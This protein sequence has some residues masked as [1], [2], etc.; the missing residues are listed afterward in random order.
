MLSLFVLIL[1]GILGGIFSPTEGGAI[2]AVGAFVYALFRRRINK[3]VFLKATAEAT[4]ITCKLIMILIGVGIL[5]AFLAAT[6]LPFQLADLIT[7]LELNRYIIFSAIVLLYIILGCV[8]NVIPIILLTLPAIFPTVL[9][10]NFD[11]IW[12]GVIS[13]ILMEMGQ[14]T[15][16]IGIIVFAVSSVAKDVPMETIFK[17]IIPFVICMILCVIILT[18]FPQIA[19]F[20][21]NLLFK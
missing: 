5:G 16:P 8:L 12:F 1:G 2:G 17:G 9:A 6:R 13:V 18:V 3:E 19:L 10:L 7:G 15:P 4:N 21:P 11:P 20:L 14:I